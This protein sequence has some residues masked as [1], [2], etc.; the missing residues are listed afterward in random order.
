VLA[1]GAAAVPALVDVLE[2]EEL[3]MADG[4]GDGWAPIH[5]ARLLGELRAESAVPA[6]VRVLCELG[7]NALLHGALIHALVQVGPAV[8]PPVLAALDSEEALEEV[9]LLEVLAQCGAKSEVIFTR[10][11]GHFLDDPD[12]GA[13]LLAYYGDSRAL[14][15]LHEVLNAYTPE[16]E[17]GPFA[18]QL[19]IEIED[20]IRALGGT[21]SP[22]QAR[23][24]DTVVSW[25]KAMF[26][27]PAPIRREARP[28]RNAPCWCGSGKKYKKCHLAEDEGRGK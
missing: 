1:L 8:A 4:P 25:R 15:L 13:G 2:D 20:A 3:S 7:V 21:L 28:E 19:V 11:C 6:M 5:A 14:P 10:L 22:D 17:E 9:G 16:G 24:L 23:K 26:G 12:L 18:G 27:S